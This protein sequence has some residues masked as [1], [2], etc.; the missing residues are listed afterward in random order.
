MSLPTLVLI[1]GLW[2]DAALFAPQ[3]QALADVASV[4]IADV[5]QD[6]TLA[7]MAQRLL[8]SIDGPFALAGLSMGGYVA[9]EVM[10]QAADRVTHLALLDTNARA[11][12]AE[13]QAQRTALVD[14]V[15]NGEGRTVCDELLEFLIHPDHMS[16]T[17]LV[18]TIHAMADRVG[19]AGFARQQNAIMFRPDGRD[20]LSRITQPTLCLCGAQDAITPPKVHQEMV[21]LLPHGTLA[22]IEN[23]G[24]LSTLERPKEVSAH[25]RAWLCS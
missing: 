15:N 19:T 8:A 10:R 9:Q 24:H 23:C 21:D 12:R 11:D 18:E 25:L 20:D 3:T 22:V 13:Q 2:T 4:K 6:D 1:P 7:G 17:S 5:G 16:D 14:R